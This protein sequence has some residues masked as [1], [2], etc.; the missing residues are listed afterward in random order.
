MDIM[1]V[2]DPCLLGTAVLELTAEQE[3]ELKEK[4]GEDYLTALDEADSDE[5]ADAENVGEA[6]S[7]DD[8][9]VD[10]IEEVEEGAAISEADDSDI[11]EDGENQ[12]T[13]M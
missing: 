7:G 12:A 10:E 9:M 11:E 1:I 8:D 3:K 2:T 5:D 4:Y 13:T 6:L